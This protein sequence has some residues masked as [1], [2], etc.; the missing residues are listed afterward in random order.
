MNRKKVLSYIDLVF[1]KEDIIFYLGYLMCSEMLITDREGALFIP[2]VDVDYIAIALGMAITSKKR[3][4]IV[5]EDWLLLKYFKSVL[6]IGA[7]KCTNIVIILLVTGEYTES[8]G[9]PTIYNSLRSMQGVFFNLGLLTYDYTK[10]FKNKNTLKSIIN[11]V[12]HFNS[13]VVATIKIDDNRL[14]NISECSTNTNVFI[15]NLKEE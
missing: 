15:D 7:S 3:V 2:N 5:C 13:P 9:Q 6:Q 8:G 12:V 1:P 11:I 10:Y 4:V 14:F